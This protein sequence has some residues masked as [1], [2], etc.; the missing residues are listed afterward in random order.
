MP[1]ISIQT[2][3]FERLQ[4]N[5]QPLVDTIDSVIIRALDALEIKAPPATAY[6]T[7]SNVQERRID[8]RQL[9]KLTHS[10]VLGAAIAGTPVTR[11]NWN[12]LLDEI[13]LLAM[14]RV[15]TFDKVQKLCPVNMVSGRK[16][17]EGYNYL[18]DVDISVQGQDSNGACRAIVTVT[19]A[20]GIELEISL[21]WR[22]KEGAAF[23]GERARIQ[24]AGRT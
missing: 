5:A 1:D 21:M 6:H 3:T 12:L 9:P 18:H 2:S 20:L 15:G 16:E 13:L 17:D 4:S 24:I 10:K 23:P 8:P 14:K 19:Q 11:P 22:H 7:S